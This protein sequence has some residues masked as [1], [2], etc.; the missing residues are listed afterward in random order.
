ML[1]GAYC[2]NPLDAAGCYGLPAEPGCCSLLLRGVCPDAAID[3]F[4]LKMLNPGLMLILAQLHGVA[5]FGYAVNAGLESLLKWLSF[6]VFAL[7]LLG[8]AGMD[9]CRGGFGPLGAVLGLKAIA[10]VYRA[11]LF[12]LVVGAG[13]VLV[14]GCGC[15]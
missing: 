6:P 4:W 12:W 15:F 5:A 11:D 9:H 2:P 10:A 8:S 7:S 3:P 13:D 14:G 1:A